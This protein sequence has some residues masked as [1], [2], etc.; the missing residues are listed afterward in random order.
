MNPSY[1]DKWDFA[2]VGQ[3]EV[4][5]KGGSAWGGIWGGC[6]PLPTE[7]S[8]ACVAPMMLQNH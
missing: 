6:V 3:E 2:D 5:G 4:P 1:I 8:V 7:A